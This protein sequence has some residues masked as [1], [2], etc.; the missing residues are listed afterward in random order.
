MCVAPNRGYSYRGKRPPECRRGRLASPNRIGGFMPLTKSG[1]KV[2]REMEKEYGQ[3]KG[4]SVFYES[5]NKGKAG[6][7]KWHGSDKKGK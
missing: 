2:L 3:R 7:Q 1:R 4:K 6:S 5:I